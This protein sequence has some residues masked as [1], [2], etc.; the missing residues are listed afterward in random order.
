[1]VK[2]KNNFIPNFQ[3]K[4]VISW[5]QIQFYDDTSAH[6]NICNHKNYAMPLQWISY[7]LHK[8]MHHTMISDVNLIMSNL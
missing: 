2:L 6:Q 3:F 4:R 5:S 7:K 8:T 1:M